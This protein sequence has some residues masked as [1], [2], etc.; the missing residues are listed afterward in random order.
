LDLIEAGLLSTE[1]R[2]ELQWVNHGNIFEGRL[3]SD[4]SIRA[5]TQ[6]GWMQFRSLS[7]AAQHISGRPQNGWQHW[8]RVNADGSKTPLENI[9]NQFRS[10]RGEM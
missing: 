9:R 1:D 8:R 10:D 3:E 6:D 2:L 4:G 5:N 7:T